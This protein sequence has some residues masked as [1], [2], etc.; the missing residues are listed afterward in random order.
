MRVYT[1]GR[2]HL[3]EPWGTYS[4]DSIGHWEGDTLV[5]TTIGL[6]GNRD[7]DSI[8]DR[9]GLV[10]SDAARGTTRMRKTDPN[11]IEVQMTIEDP[12]ALTKPWVVTK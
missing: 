11:T 5:F 3:D 1:D 10:L 8:L 12:K 7:G 2:K 4:G 9:T 6:K